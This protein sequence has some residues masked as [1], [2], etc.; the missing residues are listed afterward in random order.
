[1]V[2]C[3]ILDSPE[4]WLG[5]VVCTKILSSC[6]YPPGQWCNCEHGWILGFSFSPSLWLVLFLL[7]WEEQVQHC[8]HVS[9]T[10]KQYS[11]WLLLACGKPFIA[12]LMLYMSGVRGTMGAPYNG[13]VQMCCSLTMAGACTQA[14][15]LLLVPDKGVR[16][17]SPPFWTSM[18]S[19]VW[20]EACDWLLPCRANQCQAFKSQGQGCSWIF[21][22]SSKFYLFL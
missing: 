21:R 2:L 20:A 14:S 12:V 16:L 13:W 22:T 15:V 11:C 8:H 1:M 7:P 9:Y 4:P 18:S 3:L 10:N 5:P 19:T 17:P 6:S